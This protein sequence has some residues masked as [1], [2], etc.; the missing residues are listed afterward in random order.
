M[1]ESKPMLR[2]G[3]RYHFPSVEAMN[4]L[5]FCCG[6]CGRPF[7]GNDAE[8]LIWC[9][10]CEP[11]VLRS[12]SLWMRTWYAQHKELCPFDPEAQRKEKEREGQH[13]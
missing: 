6:C 13:G 1:S 7:T 2:V 3:K 11:H 8:T 4:S 10:D 12:G 5:T 9:D